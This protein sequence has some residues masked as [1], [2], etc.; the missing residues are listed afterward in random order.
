MKLSDVR[1][2]FKEQRTIAEE[3]LPPLCHLLVP[4]SVLGI[5]YCGLT[6]RELVGDVV[7]TASM[8]FYFDSG[9]WC[10]TCHES[11]IRDVPP[12]PPQGRRIKK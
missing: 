9:N 6:T 8:P 4:T 12:S 3:R 10:T 11:L 2:R 1:E 7:A 5:T